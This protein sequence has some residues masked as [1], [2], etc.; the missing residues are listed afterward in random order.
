VQKKQTK[1]EFA[2]DVNDGSTDGL[3]IR[4]NQ[5]RSRTINGLLEKQT[6][7]KGLIIKLNYHNFSLAFY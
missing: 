7:K 4:G 6:N 2:I 1:V 5:L 3:I